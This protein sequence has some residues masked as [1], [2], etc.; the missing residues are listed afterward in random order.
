MEHDVDTNAASSCDGDE[1]HQELLRAWGKTSEKC[2]LVEKVW[3]VPRNRPAV[4]S[5]CGQG[6][7]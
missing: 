6:L 7:P 5:L 4:S 3:E 2:D 1:E